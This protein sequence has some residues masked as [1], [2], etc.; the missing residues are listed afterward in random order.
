MHRITKKVAH[1]MG[2]IA[3]EDE[4]CTN[5]DFGIFLVQCIEYNLF[6]LIVFLSRMDLNLS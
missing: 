5:S 2:E 1:Y 6:H 3:S 4:V